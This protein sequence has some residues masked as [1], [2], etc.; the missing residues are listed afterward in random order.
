MVLC[1]Q[2]DTDSNSEW[3]M[4]NN[5]ILLITQAKIEG[6]VKKKKCEDFGAFGKTRS[7]GGLK[8]GQLKSDPGCRQSA[9]GK[10]IAPAEGLTA[11]RAR[12]GCGGKTH[13]ALSALE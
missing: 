9:A 7:S 4:K 6:S 10:S 8:E 12:C 3:K 1:E 13:R 2:L 5:T 11:K